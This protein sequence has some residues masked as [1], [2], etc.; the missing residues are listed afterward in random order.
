MKNELAHVNYMDGVTGVR[1]G[2]CQE[3]LCCGRSLLVFEREHTPVVA[4]SVKSY[5]RQCRL[6]LEFLMSCKS[7]LLV[8]YHHQCLKNLY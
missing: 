7:I 5:Q 4:L 3:A 1:R 8:E 6:K 2:D